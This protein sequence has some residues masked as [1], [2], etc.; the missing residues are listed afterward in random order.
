MVKE[1]E[2]IGFGDV[3]DENFHPRS[4]VENGNGYKLVWPIDVNGNEKK[5]RYARQSVESILNLLRV[6]KSNNGR[7]EI[8]IGKPYG[9]VKTVWQNPKYDAA[10]YGTKLVHELVPN[11]NFDF[12]KSVYN[13]YD[14]I[15]PIISERK[16]AIVLDF[17]AGSGT[18]GHATIMLNKE[19]N[20]SRKFILCT[21][22]ENGI[23]EEIC[24]PRIKAVIDGNEK[25]K[26]ITE[27]A[28]NLKYFKTD[29]VDSAPTDLNKKVLVD[30][31]TEMLCLKEYCF[32]LIR[33]DAN[34]RVFSG[35]TGK[36]LGI[37]Y[38]DAGIEG[39]KSEVRRINRKF[40]VYIFSL[41]EGVKEDEFEEIAELVDLKPIPASILN[42][43]RR[44]YR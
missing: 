9:T 34:F 5:W 13:V 17:F 20:G 42:V 32:N 21:N 29:F 12:P 18:T 23:A 40:S 30:R 19:D 37:I 25:Y 1:S 38:D 44:I 33:N 22:N 16:E 35:A 3:P 2:I 43:Y 10:E 36:Y 15:A 26:E 6:K 7:I 28:T 27:Y 31:S 11:S 39:L 24:Y 4:Q 41:D 14:C 8:E